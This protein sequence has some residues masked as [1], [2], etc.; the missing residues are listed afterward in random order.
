VDGDLINYK[1]TKGK[2]KHSTYTP[3]SSI[4]K[5]QD[6]FFGTGKKSVTL[7]TKRVKKG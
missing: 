4:M 7:R 6:I 2:E 5:Q 3:I 1:E